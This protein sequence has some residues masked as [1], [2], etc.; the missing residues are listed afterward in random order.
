MRVIDREALETTMLA[1]L[2][3][4][5]AT[6]RERHPGERREANGWDARQVSRHSEAS[7]A[8]PG[9]PSVATRK[10][11]LATFEA[12]RTGAGQPRVVVS[13]RS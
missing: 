6:L 3:A 9:Q 5:W 13:R 7:G 1:E 8:T 10:P 11:P 12:T 4:A 2:R